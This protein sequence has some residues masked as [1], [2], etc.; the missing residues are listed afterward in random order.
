M[1][2]KLHTFSKQII[3]FSIFYIISSYAFADY[4]HIYLGGIVGK[5]NANIGNTNNEIIYY[6]GSLVDKY[7]T[8]QRN[9]HAMIAGINSGYEFSDPDS[10]LAMAVGLGLYGT[11]GSAYGYSG[12]VIETTPSN[13]DAGDILYN[14]K[15]NIRSTRL[16]GE[17]R[18]S[19][20]LGYF[21]PFIDLGLGA[22]WNHMTGYQELP[23]SFPGY[24]ALPPFQSKTNTHFAYQ[25]GFGVGFAFDSN[26]AE[27]RRERISLGYRFVNLGDASYGTRGSAYPY[28]FK[29]G[30]L[31]TQ[32]IYLIYTWLF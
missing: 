25:A 5:S 6:N 26:A 12:Q 27:I 22:T 18:L 23:F 17:A 32:E 13:P 30:K 3:I 24:T 20:L 4:G 9:A 1:T 2:R 28:P 29:T 19:W 15:Y 16:M 14:Y 21:V 10:A 11:P 7:P 8:Q 31:K